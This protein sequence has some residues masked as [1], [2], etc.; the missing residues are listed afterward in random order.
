[1]KLVQE[2]DW[3]ILNL[4]F[5]HL[6]NSAKYKKSNDF[7]NENHKAIVHN[8]RE[9]RQQF[10][11][12]FLECKNNSEP[13]ELDSA[14]LRGIIKPGVEI[15]CLDNEELKRYLI[16]HIN[17][18]GGFCDDCSI[19]KDCIVIRYRIWIPEGYLVPQ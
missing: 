4:P 5:G 12:I 19:S 14:Q 3:I 13:E 7:Y 15:E 16:G 8:D 6:Y 2:P 11:K 18:N 1:M 9:V 17:N 10:E